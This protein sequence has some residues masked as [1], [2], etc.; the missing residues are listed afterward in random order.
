MEYDDVMVDLETF[1]SGQNACVVQIGACYFDRL[2]GGIGATF[3]TTIDAGSAVASGAQIDADTIYWWLSQSKEAINSITANPK[4]GIELAFSQLNL[5]LKDSKYIWSHATFDFV[6]I[7]ETLRRLK[8]K[9]LFH[10]RNARD[11]R[12]LIDISG[13]DIKRDPHPRVG[14]HHDGLDDAIY[15]A[16][17]CAAA[18]KHLFRLAGSST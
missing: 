3:K 17:Y 1:G 18:V 15:Q 11:I 14:V 12:T 2:T 4:A 16:Q 6:I 10:Y 7:M 13:I 9:P 8:I 5:F